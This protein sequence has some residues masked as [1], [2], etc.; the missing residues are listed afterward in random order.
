VETAKFSW[1]LRARRKVEGVYGPKRRNYPTQMRPKRVFGLV[2]V[3]CHH[4]YWVVRDPNQRE[5]ARHSAIGTSAEILDF[6]PSAT[7]VTR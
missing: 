1:G 4:P 3:R 6:P 7:I 5:V 2:L